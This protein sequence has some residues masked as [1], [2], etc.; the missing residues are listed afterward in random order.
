MTVGDSVVSNDRDEARSAARFDRFG[1]TRVGDR[2][3]DD[4]D[5]PDL[6]REW[7]E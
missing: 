6:G 2:W 3:I 5:L 4:P 7:D 1:A